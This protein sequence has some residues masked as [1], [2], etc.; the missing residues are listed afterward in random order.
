MGDGNIHYDV[1]P[2]DPARG[3]DFADKIHA[4]EQA[5]YDVIDSCEGSISAE[6]GIGLARRDD[7]IARE[8]GPALD[9]MR[10]MK[11][12]LDPLGIMNPGKMI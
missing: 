12:A 4:I 7:L 5:V 11:S 3:A 1:L 6:H 8:T 9:M 10:A 2:P